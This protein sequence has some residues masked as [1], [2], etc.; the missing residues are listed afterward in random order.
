MPQKKD[1]IMLSQEEEHN[2]RVSALE[3]AVDNYGSFIR[4]YFISLALGLAT[5]LARW[6]GF[7]IREARASGMYVNTSLR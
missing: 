1:L 5:L 3:A 4:K 7:C 2:A 6:Y